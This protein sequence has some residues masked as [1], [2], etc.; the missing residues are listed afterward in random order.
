VYPEVW[1]Q[2]DIDSFGVL[3]EKSPAWARWYYDSRM[4]DASFSPFYLPPIADFDPRALL[5]STGLGAGSVVVSATRK[6]LLTAS[7]A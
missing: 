3:E 2:H 4:I 7:R 1:T 6:F 5:I